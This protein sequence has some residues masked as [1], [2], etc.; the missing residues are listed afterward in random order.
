MQN[1]IAH[2][3]APAASPSLNDQRRA[4]WLH[5]DY[6]SPVWTVSDTHDATRR[7]TIDFRYMLADGRLLTESP[8]LLATVREYAWWVRDARFSRVDDAFVHLNLVRNL[9]HLSHRLTL[10]GNSSFSHLV[11][12]DIEQIVEACRFGMDA[13]LQASDRVAVYLAR[14]LAD[15]NSRSGPRLP[16]QITKGQTSSK[17]VA[18]TA[19]VIGCSLP[20][21]AAKLPRV[22]WRIA[23]AA[24]QAG[25]RGRAISEEEP[26]LTPQTV[27]ALQRWLDPLEQLYAMRG[28]MKADT[29]SF[30]PFA[31]GAARVA[32]VKGIATERTPTPPPHLALHLLEGAA[33][34]IVSDGARNPATIEECR[35]TATACWIVIAT[36]TARRDEEID[37]LHEDCLLGNAEDGWWLN[38]YIEKTL[39]R[40][41]PIPVPPLVE[42]AV[43][44][45]LAI[46]QGARDACGNGDLFQWLDPSGE[47]T[48]LDVGRRLDD[49]AAWVGVPLHAERGKAAT[50]WHWHPHQFR[51]FFAI[52]YFYRFEGATLEAL[53]HHL[54]HFNLEMTRRYVTRD[55]AAAAIWTDVQWGYMGHV[56]RSIAAGERSVSGAAGARLKKAA[57]RILDTLRR[58]L[59]VVSPERAGASLTMLMQRQGL[60]LTP[61]PWVTCSCPATTLAAATAACRRG[62]DTLEPGPDFA[63]AGPSVC[64]DCPHAITEGDRRGI[65]VD[66][67]QASSLAGAPAEGPRT[68]FG[69]LEA[70]RVL[71]IQ[72]VIDDLDAATPLTNPANQMETTR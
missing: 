8:R 28:R 56:A 5:S 18:P 47:L 42:R 39:Q 72:R 25:L 33:R 27:Q 2:E 14:Q 26:E 43:S 38:I 48:K 69:E 15:E 29:L 51:R 41:E 40:V 10:D 53:S 32:A 1:A 19:I 37:E 34:H 12:Y 46:S 44:A 24:R 55:R 58:R 57:K 31:Q 17:L 62:Q 35:R 4:A 7:E 59:T 61:K 68:M 36:F 16:V 6:T 11:P 66:R 65:L 60:V 64:G 30:K 50:A 70:A 20:P 22:S 49:F 3:L 63:N 67:S 45:L 13:V 21:S 71:T 54:R 9:M 23:T 52:L